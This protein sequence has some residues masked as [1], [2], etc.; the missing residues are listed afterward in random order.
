L[1]DNQ[2]ITTPIEGSQRVI[3]Q[4]REKR[5]KLDMR[6]IEKQIAKAEKII[7]G[8][9][10]VQ[11][12]KF[13]SVKTKEKKLNQTLLD[14][15]KALVGVKGYVTNLN[16][17]DEQV[18]TAYHQLWHVEQSFRM[19]KSD[20]KARPIFL[21]KQDSIEAHLTIVLAALAMGKMIESRTGISIKRFVNTL[22]PIRSGIVIIN[23]KEYSAEAGISPEVRTIIRKLQA[24]H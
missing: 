21:R 24:G 10:A 2:I 16:I 19:S 7:N 3:Y 15:A 20:L 1:T 23:G 22:R 4:Y 14:K 9:I 13:L 12:A 18:I 17:P 5:A 6:N 11:K 8:K